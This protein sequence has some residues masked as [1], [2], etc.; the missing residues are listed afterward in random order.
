ML[1][2]REPLGHVDFYPSGLDPISDGCI[3]IAFADSRAWVYSVY[4]GNEAGF[5]R[6]SLQVIFFFKFQHKR[7]IGP[8][9]TIGYNV[10]TR[11]QG[12]FY[13]S[14]NKRFAFGLNSNDSLIKD[15][16]GSG[17]C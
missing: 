13:S 15:R 4:P 10:S 11:S 1:G 7:C 9:H 5:C 16:H 3:T 17:N 2:K 6:E 8:R 14:I 12:L